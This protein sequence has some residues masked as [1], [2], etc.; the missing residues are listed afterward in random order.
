MKPT[1]NPYE[2]ST[3]YAR[4]YELLNK[5]FVILGFKENLK[6]IQIQLFNDIYYFQFESIFKDLIPTFEDFSDH[7]ASENI[8]F[9]DVFKTAENTPPRPFEVG[10]EVISLE[11]GI[12]KVMKIES[13]KRQ[14]SV[15]FENN[16]TE[17]LRT[18]FHAFENPKIVTQ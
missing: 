11:F 18:I 1:Q 14:I 4:L 2:L 3:D 8:S 6:L 17:K 9:I 12:G 15:D 13:D 5:G 7:C 10:D 16:K